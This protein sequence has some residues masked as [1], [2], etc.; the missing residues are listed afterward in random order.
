MTE[1]EFLRRHD[2]REMLR[3][4]RDYC[5]GRGDTED[6][7]IGC[8][9]S[10][11]CM[12]PMTN[13]DDE[14]IE[15]ITRALQPEPGKGAETY[16]DEFLAAFPQ[17]EREADGTPVACRNHIFGEGCGPCMLQQL[18]EAG[19]DEDGIDEAACTLCAQCWRE[20]WR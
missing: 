16:M 5:E 17:A 11:I 2:E 15:R 6:A 8:A 1:R 14:R 9:L 19:A 4:M 13:L 10:A 3:R 12:G 7:C 18:A 20:A